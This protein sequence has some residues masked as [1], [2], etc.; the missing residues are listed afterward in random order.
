[1]GGEGWIFSGI[2][3]YVMV[4]YNTAKFAP[5]W[6]TVFK[7]RAIFVQQTFTE[8]ALLK[9]NFDVTFL[10]LNSVSEF[11]KKYLY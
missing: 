7:I 1:M 4:I 10:P 6:T 11:K 3:Q 9:L 2:A 5:V 8:H